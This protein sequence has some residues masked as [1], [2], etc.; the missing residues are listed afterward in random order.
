MNHGVSVRQLSAQYNVHMHDIVEIQFSLIF[1]KYTK[2]IMPSAAYC[3]L[4][5]FSHH[6]CVILSYMYP[7]LHRYLVELMNCGV[8]T[9]I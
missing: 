7:I 2:I 5:T 3:E 6:V 4:V 8:S 9:I 1:G